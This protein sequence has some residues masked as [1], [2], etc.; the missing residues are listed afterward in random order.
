MLTSKLLTCPFRVLL[1]CLPL[2]CLAGGASGPV[3]SAAV[4]ALPPVDWT[5]LRYAAN[6][7]GVRLLTTLRLAVS[8][9]RE[10]QAAPYAALSNE[11]FQTATGAVLRLDVQAHAESLLDSYDMLGQVWFAPG[12]IAALQRE[13][14]K[15]GPNGSLKIYRFAPGGA[16]RIKLE[17]N[18]R[19]E[20]RRNPPSWTRLKRNFYPYDLAAAGCRLATTPE[21][22]LYLASAADPVNGGVSH[23]VFVDD[24]LYRVWLVPDGEAAR[25]VDYIVKTGATTRRLDGERKTLKLALRVEPVVPGADPSA[26]ELLELRGAI[27]I[28]LDSGT[29]LPVLITGERAGAGE[30]SVGLV[31][32]VM[33]E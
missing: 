28:Y 10:M 8:S 30:L 1:L 13:R 16:F 24:A 9:R 21:L 14:M 2:Y 7:F 23:C 3:P 33:R 18:G 27:A 17:P 32:A 12:D 26:F 15:P 20:G 11:P 19:D 31:E 6:R 25:P 22:L 5:S 29:R 4:E